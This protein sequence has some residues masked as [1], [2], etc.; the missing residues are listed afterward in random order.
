MLVTQQSGKVQVFPLRLSKQNKT[1]SQTGWSGRALPW[2]GVSLVLFA[3]PAWGAES[4]PAL[5]LITAN[6]AGSEYGLSLQILV[7]MT[8]LAII[9]S[10]VILMT[11]FTRIIIVLSLLRQAMGTGQTPPNQVLIGIAVFLSFFIMKPVFD[12]VYDQAYVPVEQNEI[13]F[14]EGLVAAL[15]P[16]REFMM[17]QVREKDLM[18]FMEMSGQEAVQSQDDIPLSTLIP[19]FLTSELKTAFTIGFL[20]YIPF[21]I[22]DLVVASVLMSMGMMMLSPMM[23]SMPF[24]LLLFVLVDGWGLIT[25]SLVSTFG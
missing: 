2:I 22:I 20:I 24:K 19:A 9:P 23:I 17:A 16:L 25:G 1:R 15:P 13:T 8:V 18:M 11:S 21:V 4:G 10:I 12:E 5:T 6:D 3:L 7:M 14:Q